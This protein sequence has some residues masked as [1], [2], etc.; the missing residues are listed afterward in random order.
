MQRLHKPNE[1]RH[2]RRSLFIFAVGISFLVAVL[3]R[4]AISAAEYEPTAGSRERVPVL[5]M[6]T[7]ANSWGPQQNLE[8]NAA[9]RLAPNGAI[10][11]YGLC[12]GV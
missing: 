8:S 9:S 3:A 10:M 5:I 12:R 2:F 6:C 11:Q 7:A 4:T 1:R